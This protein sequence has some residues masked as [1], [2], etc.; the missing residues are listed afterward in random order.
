[1]GIIPIEA[2]PASIYLAEHVFVGTKGDK[3]VS[4]SYFDIQDFADY[5]GKEY[6]KFNE[7]E[8][9]ALYSKFFNQYENVNILVEQWWT[10]R[11]DMIIRMFSE[12]D[13][14]ERFSLFKQRVYS[15]EITEYDTLLMNWWQNKEA[16]AEREFL[17]MTDQQR[18]SLYMKYI[19]K[20]ELSPYNKFLR[21]W[22]FNRY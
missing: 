15:E 13:E 19:N 11:K 16:Q 9:D 3:A 8:R 18:L 5:F 20:D 10:E 2:I 1:M 12:K 14:E 17:E 21:A 4:I 7:K 6:V 22:W